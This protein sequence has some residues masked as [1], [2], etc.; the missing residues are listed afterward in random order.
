MSFW[1]NED[2][3]APHIRHQHSSDLTNGIKQ[4]SLTSSYTFT[5]SGVWILLLPLA[6]ISGGALV[7]MGDERVPA[8]LELLWCSSEDERFPATNLTRPGGLHL[9]EAEKF[10]EFPQELVFRVNQGM[11]TRIEQVNLLSHPT[12][13]ATRIEIFTSTT[14]SAAIHD[15]KA[16][17][18]F[19]R[20][21]FVCF[22][23]NDTAE[24]TL[25]ELQE[26]QLPRST[27]KITLLRLVLHSCH[28][29]RANLFSQ[30]G[31]AA[32]A[33]LGPGTETKL[34]ILPSPRKYPANDVISPR[35]GSD[36][37]FDTTMSRA[38]KENMM[39][40]PRTADIFIED[41][42][43]V[44]TPEQICA[45]IQIGAQLARFAGDQELVQS[46]ISLG[47]ESKHLSNLL[48]R[49]AHPDIRDCSR[50]TLLT[51]FAEIEHE[52]I[53][54]EGI[55]CQH[56]SSSARRNNETS[57][58]AIQ[59][60]QT[61][62]VLTRIKTSQ[63][64]ERETI[65]WNL[66]EYSQTLSGRRNG[67]PMMSDGEALEILA[68]ALADTNT[69]V[70]IAGCAVFRELLTSLSYFQDAVASKLDVSTKTQNVCCFIW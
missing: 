65:L 20:L 10:C 16:G 3:C 54:Q 57:S 56:M 18:K 14:A 63:G 47:L 52:R 42:Q 59:G 48:Q 29:A 26:V 4:V 50:G 70:F 23:S 1:N 17:V 64:Q 33:A 32:V 68:T 41:S 6:S 35:R 13:V 9:W 46:W 12:K 58:A 38:T 45:D 30:V 36:N 69:G 22:T 19:D 34:P 62:N 8:H 44:K 5:L 66:A 49:S 21:G 11:P 55:L 31:L 43:E 2:W 27:G 37:L 24:T 7:E 53:Q 51:R 28:Q 40:S 60:A 61:H 25:C 39:K 67:L 15:G